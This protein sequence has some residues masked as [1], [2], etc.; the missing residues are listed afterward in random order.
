MLLRKYWAVL[1]S[2]LLAVT[3]TLW[4]RPAAAN[5]SVENVGKTWDI[6]PNFLLNSESSYAQNSAY[7][8]N[9][10]QVHLNLVRPT[11]ILVIYGGMS[12]SQSTNDLIINPDNYFAVYPGVSFQPSWSPVAAFVEY[13]SYATDDRKD[14]RTGFYGYHWIDLPTRLSKNFFNETYGDVLYSSRQSQDVVLSASTKVGHRFK[15]SNQFV[16]DTFL[17]GDIRRDHQGLG[18]NNLQE[19]LPGVR[20]T[21]FFQPFSAALTGNYAIGSLANTPRSYRDV[22]F[23]LSLSGEI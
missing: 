19:F 6:S 7:I 11:S 17:E 8:V 9:Q 14:L 16:T 12:L 23:T 2:I 21:L 5:E 13:W 22:R 10:S 18:E 1:L 15:F 3:I 4:L 20:S